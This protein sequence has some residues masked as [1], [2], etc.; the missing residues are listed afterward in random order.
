MQ[1]INLFMLQDYTKGFD[2]MRWQKLWNMLE[3]I[4]IHH[5]IFIT[6]SLYG[7]NSVRVEGELTEC[8]PISQGV[9]QDCILGPML[10]HIRRRDYE[11]HSTELKAN[12]HQW[13]QNY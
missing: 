8:F 1:H 13:H 4:G 9:R 7:N 6:K 3:E 12:N 5:L 2:C 10:S 11:E